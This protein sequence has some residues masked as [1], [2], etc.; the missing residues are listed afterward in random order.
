MACPPWSRTPD[1][2]GSLIS[3]ITKAVRQALQMAA[4]A[5]GAA[6]V[7][8]H[9]ATGGVMIGASIILSRALAPVELAIGSWR[10]RRDGCG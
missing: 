2:R 6:L 7:I 3:A 1:P 9:E 5:V 8:R 10:I 4:L